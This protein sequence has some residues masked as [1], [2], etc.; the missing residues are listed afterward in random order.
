MK[1]KRE[2]EME[3]MEMD[4]MIRIEMMIII[5]NDKMMITNIKMKTKLF[6]LP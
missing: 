2:I 1:R 5:I 6:C 4:N 3:E